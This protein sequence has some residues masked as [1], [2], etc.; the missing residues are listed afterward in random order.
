M[1]AGQRCCV[2]LDRSCFYAE[3]GG[4]SHDQGYFT[5]T[6]LPV[7]GGSELGILGQGSLPAET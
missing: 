6:E 2:I 4:Q 5:K 7:S 3:Q 1:C